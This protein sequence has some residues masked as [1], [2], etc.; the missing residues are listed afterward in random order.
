M[1]RSKACRMRLIEIRQ[2]LISD[3]AG[4]TR[5]TAKLEGALE[6]LL[7]DPTVFYNPDKA[8]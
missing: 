1:P 2:D 6:G 3:D 4:V 7:A 8:T 5:W